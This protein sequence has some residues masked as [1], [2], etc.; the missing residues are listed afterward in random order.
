MRKEFIDL[1]K[2]ESTDEAKLTGRLIDNDPNFDYPEWS[3]EGIYDDK[4]AVLFYRTTPYDQK[5][6]DETGDWS[7]VE[8]SARITHIECLYPD[9]CNVYDCATIYQR[10]ILN[11]LDSE[12][13][14]EVMD[15][16]IDKCE[17][18]YRKEQALKMVLGGE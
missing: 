11:R 14:R 7:S 4:C 9:E 10:A 8:W 2:W 17:D 6:A 18:G 5:I 12:K 15:S 1:K 3:E 16:I 13:Y